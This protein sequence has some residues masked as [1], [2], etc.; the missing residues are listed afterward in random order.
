MSDGTPAGWF[1]QFQLRTLF[2]EAPTPMSVVDLQGRYLRVNP[3]MC[4][5]LGRPEAAVTG[6]STTVVTHPDDQ[7]DS[8]GVVRLLA[9]GER[10][11]MTGPKRFVR[12]DGTVVHAVRTATMVPDDAGRPSF[13]VAQYV[14]VGAAAPTALPDEQ[15]APGEGL[16]RALVRVAA[17]TVGAAA[18]VWMRTAEGG[19]LQS[20]AWWHRD[21]DVLAVLDRLSPVSVLPGHGVAGLVALT[22]R[23]LS[24]SRPPDSGADLVV[25]GVRL[26]GT[27]AV[28]GLPLTVGGVVVGVLTLTRGPGGAPYD[29]EEQSFARALARRVGRALAREQPEPGGHSVGIP[30]PRVASHDQ[31]HVPED[32]LAVCDWL[33]QSSRAEDG[34]ASDESVAA[35]CTLYRCLIDLGWVAPRRVEVLLG[36][37][38]RL[39]ERQLEVLLGDNGPPAT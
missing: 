1:G 7:A 6:Q 9:A 17:E 18:A 34:T 39:R 31:A 10:A 12:P 37:Q 19:P 3:A 8:L 27:A 33:V 25:D 30:R 21:Q 20:V 35:R 23:P 5:M 4:R 38:D 29:A 22:G 24:A 36:M 28:M 14:E 15:E 13:L 2:S 32:L 16:L 26:T 11:A